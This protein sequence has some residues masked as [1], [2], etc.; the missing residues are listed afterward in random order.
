MRNH[1]KMASVAL[2]LAVLVFVVGLA[3]CSRNATT[4]PVS[5]ATPLATATFTAA[6]TFTPTAPP[7][8]AVSRAWEDLLH[9]AA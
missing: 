9:C 5:T 6:A 1:P 4:A 2:S 7:C 8:A 3:S